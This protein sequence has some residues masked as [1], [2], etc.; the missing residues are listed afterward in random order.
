MK[1]ATIITEAPRRRRFTEEQ[2]TS[3][4]AEM[5]EPGMTIAQLARRYEISQAL[6]YNWRRDAAKQSAFVRIVP[7]TAHSSQSSSSRS[8]PAARICS[9]SGVIIEF[10]SSISIEDIA[11][12]ASRLGGRS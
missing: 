5:A 7:T 9:P 11:Y 12:L 2:K 6:L 4:L 1:K 8:L 3:I 10:A